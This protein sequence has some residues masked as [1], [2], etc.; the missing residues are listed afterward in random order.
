MLRIEN[1]LVIR[2]NRLDTEAIELNLLGPLL[3]CGQLL[4]GQALHRLAETEVHDVRDDSGQGLLWEKSRRGILNAP[5]IRGLQ[6]VSEQM[7]SSRCAFP[8]RARSAMISPSPPWR[9]K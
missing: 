8:L 9:R 3:A 4:C 6:L 5:L 7:L 2:T 1:D